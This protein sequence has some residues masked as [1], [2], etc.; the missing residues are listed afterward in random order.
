M[1]K[2]DELEVPSCWQNHGYDGHQYTNVRYPIPFCPPYVPLDNPCGLY[3]RTF[4]IKK[5]QNKRQY[6][7]F[8][9]VDSCYYLWINGKFVGYS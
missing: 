9:G 4:K 1:D 8:E 5:R 2:Y 6:L 7:N 3:R